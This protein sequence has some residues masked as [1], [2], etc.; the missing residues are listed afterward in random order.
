MPVK[1]VRSRSELPDPDDPILVGQVEWCHHIPILHRALANPSAV[2]EMPQINRRMD[3][4]GAPDR[5]D[6]KREKHEEL[7]S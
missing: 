4:I 5:K 6:L 2:V 7:S 1:L 3:L